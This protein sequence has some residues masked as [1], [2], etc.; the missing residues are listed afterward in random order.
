MSRLNHSLLLHRYVLHLFGVSSL[1]ALS[2]HMSDTRN[3][4]YDEN[5]ISQFYYILVNRLYSSE[6]LNANMLLGYD[7]NI[8]HHTTA[9]NEERDEPITWKYF[10]YLS[11]LFMEIYLDKYFNNKYKLLEEI[12]DFVD[13]FNDPFTTEVVSELDGVFPHFTLDD[14]NKLAFWNAT[15]SG[16]TLIMHVN[17]RQILS[18]ARKYKRDIY[19]N[20]L[21]ITP[22]EGLSKQHLEEL[23]LSN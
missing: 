6:L 20:I 13:Q 23:K 1:E 5:N 12:N 8:Y 21:L 3:E 14:L 15:G 7:Q 19:E 2:E 22:N 16:K 10:Q 11:L 18:Y 9:I 17:I 4:G